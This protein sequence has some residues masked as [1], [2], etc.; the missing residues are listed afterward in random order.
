MAEVDLS[1]DNDLD[2]ENKDEIVERSPKGRFLRFNDTL[3]SGAYKSVYRGY[4]N[5]SGC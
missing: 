2:T 1:S 4:D 5:D 3:G